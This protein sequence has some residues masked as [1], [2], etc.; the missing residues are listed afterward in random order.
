[1]MI[2]MASF[3]FVGFINLVDKSEKRFTV[4]FEFLSRD[5]RFLRSEKL[6]VYD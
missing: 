1:M 4:R 6:M 5:M 3:H 2:E